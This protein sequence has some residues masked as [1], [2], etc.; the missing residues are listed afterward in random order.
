[1]VKTDQATVGDRTLH[2]PWKGCEAYHFFMLAQQQLENEELKEAMNTAMRLAEFDDVLDEVDLYS[3]MA[4]TAYYAK[5]Y[6]VCSK[7]FI[8]LE[9]IEA[10][11]GSRGRVPTTL[12]HP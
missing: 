2:N 10:R 7:A 11:G 4:L 3:L 9:A 8:R 1:M 12:P 6:S 5:N